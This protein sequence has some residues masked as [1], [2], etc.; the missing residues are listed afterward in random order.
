VEFV[1]G[2]SVRSTRCLTIIAYYY[3]QS[4]FHS[5]ILAAM[6]GIYQ[7]GLLVT[8]SL[9]ILHRK[10]FLSKFGLDDVNNGNGGGMPGGMEMSQKPLRTQAAGLL[11]AVQY[12][13]IPV[14]AANIILMIFEILLGA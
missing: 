7:A 12:L 6:D 10:R 4:Q 8:N 11:M 9:M 14:I 13:K 1:Q 5:L 3:P 2:K